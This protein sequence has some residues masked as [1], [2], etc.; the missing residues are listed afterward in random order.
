MGKYSDRII[1][2]VMETIEQHE[3]GKSEQAHDYIE[4]IISDLSHMLE[5]MDSDED[6]I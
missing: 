5:R 3:M 4:S 1:E 6:D 2:E